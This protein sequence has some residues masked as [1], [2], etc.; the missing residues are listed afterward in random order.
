[1]LISKMLKSKRINKMVRLT[2]FQR[3]MGH[4]NSIVDYVRVG[5]GCLEEYYFHV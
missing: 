5:V 2:S 4:S 1:M 3:P